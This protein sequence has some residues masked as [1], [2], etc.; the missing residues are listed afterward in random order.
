MSAVRTAV[1]DGD[2]SASQCWC[3]GAI[4]DPTRLVHL[5]NH[6]EVAL[7]VRCAHSVSKW[8][9]EIEDRAKTGPL[10]LARDRFRA[11]RREVVRRG[12]HRAPVLGGP[13]R[14]IG[15]HLP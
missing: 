1:E 3:C 9:G 12:W 7:C 11:L 10:V 2:M 15:R 14:L 5:G 4:D 6:P 8:A 13:I